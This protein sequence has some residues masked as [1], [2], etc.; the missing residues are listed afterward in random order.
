MSVYASVGVSAQHAANVL[1]S[2]V[3]AA[4]GRMQ[5]GEVN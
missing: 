2:K 4:I 5:H 1:K 3:K